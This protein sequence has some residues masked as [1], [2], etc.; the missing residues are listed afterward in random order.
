MRRKIVKQGT[1]TMTI[2]LPAKGCKQHNLNNGDEVELEE[3]DTDLIISS[4]K[5]EITKSTKVDLTNL[6]ER[7]IRWMLS[8]LHKAGYTEIELIYSNISTMNIIQELLKDL[9]TGF[10][11]IEQSSKRCVIKNITRDNMEEF[12]NILRRAFLVT[13]ALG[14]ESLNLVKNKKFDDLKHV[15]G[16]EKSNNQLTNYCERLLNVKGYKNLTNFMYVIICNLEKICDDYKYVAEYLGKNKINLSD[17]TIKLYDKT[18]KILRE[19][20]ELFYKFESKKMNKIHTEIKKIKNE[21]N[22]S[23]PEKERIIVSYLLGLIMK[24]ADFSASTI[25]LNM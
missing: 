22:F 14:E 21:L 10:T 19:Q 9:F 6:D 20:Y 13:I 2:S 18:N 7:V 25:A 16:L 1:A 3:K 12:D 24:I 4:E 11:I 8:S 15:I 23:V 17:K 5:Q